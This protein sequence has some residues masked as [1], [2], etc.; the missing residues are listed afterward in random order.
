MR[1][2][3][4]RTSGTLTE[5][6]ASVFFFGFHSIFCNLGAVGERLA[7]AGNAGPVGVDHRGIGDHHLQQIFSLTDGDDLPVL[8]PPKVGECEAI[9]YAQCV[10]V[11]RG[12]GPAT[13]A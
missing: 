2:T 12:E 3:S 8:V 10:L 9:W 5:K 4:C 1:K 13:H 6:G 7:V 11:L